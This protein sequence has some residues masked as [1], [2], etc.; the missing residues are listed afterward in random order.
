M[1]VEITTRSDRGFHQYGED[2]RC[3]YGT[4]IRVYESSSAEGPH[5]WLALEQDVTVLNKPEPG[6]A[7]A[8]LDEAQARIL[9]A[10]LQA[11]VDEI[12]TRWSSRGSK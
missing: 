12:P 11:W 4:K 6:I 5:V 9:I 2:H 3:C 10:R 7:H 8:H 1:T